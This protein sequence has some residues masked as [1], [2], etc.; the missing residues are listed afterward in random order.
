MKIADDTTS[1]S[2]VIAMGDYIG[3]APV[4]RTVVG[5]YK[6][7]DINGDGS[8]ERNFIWETQPTY[9]LSFG[10]RD[11]AVGKYDQWW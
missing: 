10:I 7:A 11:G 9:S 2:H 3:P 5:W 1:A 8:D 6:Y 4:V